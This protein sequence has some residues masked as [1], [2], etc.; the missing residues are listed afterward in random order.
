MTVHVDPERNEVRALRGITN[1]RGERVLD[2]GCGDGRLSLRLA[3]LGASVVGI[4]PEGKLIR[5]ARKSLP[6]TLAGRVRYR[7]G[8]AGRLD[9]PRE[10]FDLVIFTWSF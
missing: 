9:F 1:W 2:I 5:K 6:K 4:D 8:K 3:R 7:V 10:S